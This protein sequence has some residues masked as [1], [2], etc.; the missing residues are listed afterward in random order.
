MARPFRATRTG[1]CAAFS[2][3]AA[4]EQAAAAAKTTADLRDS[5]TAIFARS[6][7]AAPSTSDHARRIQPPSAR[8]ASVEVTNAFRCA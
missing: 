7:A 2:E 4:V 1:P 6:A 5:A 3:S 8:K